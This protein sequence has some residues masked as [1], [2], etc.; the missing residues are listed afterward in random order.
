MNSR[1]ALVV[2]PGFEKEALSELRYWQVKAELDSLEIGEA[3]NGLVEVKA[4]LNHGFFLNRCLKIPV[5]IYWRLAEFRCRDFPSLFK[6]IQKLDWEWLPVVKTEWSTSSTRSRLKMK[7]RIA[8]TCEKAMKKVLKRKYPEQ[9]SDET[10]QFLVRFVDDICHLSVDT[11]GELLYKRGVQRFVGEAPLRDNLAAAMLWAMS[12]GTEFP[13]GLT[14][15]DPMAGSGVF[16]SEGLSLLSINRKRSF[17]FESF[18]IEIKDQTCECGSAVEKL[19]YND[20]NKKV[21]DLA[22]KNLSGAEVQIF[23]KDYLEESSFFQEL[24]AKDKGAWLITNPP[25]GERIEIQ[26]KKTSVL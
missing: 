19:I 8:E 24:L 17:A 16:L 10:L 12:D 3:S 1:F 22:D 6:K 25:Y 18:G 15:L 11:S 7:K 23:N 9:T 14:L 21:V 20:K 5:R 26:K 4:S 13:A 2:P